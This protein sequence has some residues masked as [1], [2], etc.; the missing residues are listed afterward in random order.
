MVR[1]TATA[2]VRPRVDQ[3][4]RERDSS[5]D[6]GEKK[7][8]R[9]WFFT[10]TRRGKTRMW[11]GTRRLSRWRKGRNA[12]ESRRCW[13]YETGLPRLRTL[14]PSF[15][16]V[17]DKC[18]NCMRRWRG[19]WTRRVSTTQSSRCAKDARF[20][21]AGRSEL[22]SPAMF[23]VQVLCGVEKRGQVR[24]KERRDMEIPQTVFVF[25]YN[26]LLVTSVSQFLA[27][28]D[29]TVKDRR[30]S[31]MSGYVV[32]LLEVATIEFGDKRMI[33][34][35]DGMMT[36]PRHW[37]LPQK[38]SMGASKIWRKLGALFPKPHRESVDLVRVYPD[39]R[40]AIQRTNRMRW[41]LP[42][43]IFGDPIL[44]KVA[45][46]SLYLE[47]R[48]CT[49]DASGHPRQGWPKSVQQKSHHFHKVACMGMFLG[50]GAWGRGKDWSSTKHG[51][52]SSLPERKEVQAGRPITV[53]RM[54]SSLGRRLW[55]CAVAEES[56]GKKTRMEALTGDT[57][58]KASAGVGADGLADGFHPKVPLDLRTQAWAFL[59]NLGQGGYWPVQASTLFSLSFS[60]ECH[61]CKTDC[62]AA[63][64]LQVVG[65]VESASHPMMEDMK[66][67]AKM[68][69]MDQG[70]VTLVVDSA[71]AF[72]IVQLKVVW[73]WMMHF[74]DF[75]TISQG[76][77]RVLS[78]SSTSAAE[79][80]VANEPGTSK[81]GTWRGRKSYGWDSQNKAGAVT[82]WRRERREDSAHCVKQVL[83]KNIGDVRKWFNLDLV[84]CGT[85][86]YWDHESDEKVGEQG[87]RVCTEN[88]CH[89]ENEWIQEN[90]WETGIWWS[91][92]DGCGDLEVYGY[93]SLWA[94]RRPREKLRWQLGS[95]SGKKPSVSSF[96]QVN[97]RIGLC[98]M[99]GDFKCMRC[100]KRSI[101]ENKPSEMVQQA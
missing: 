55:G 95:A 3:L 88:W 5:K 89:Q 76:T 64:S 15:F 1:V 25:S 72:E 83:G 71:R 31:N 8:E 29:T 36:R 45:R 4:I 37:R 46:E 14:L 43:V 42:A 70:A 78:V 9:L 27:V 11:I 58:D 67:T 77:L 60:E 44:T 68:N 84:Q 49:H 54:C 80:F 7:Y 48:V 100:A 85:L 40:T 87:E 53:E 98:C 19:Q 56:A 65:L 28:L 93:H 20:F 57:P 6:D 62:F 92:E 22:S 34:R 24:R 82:D 17:Q 38:I 86:G 66:N 21:L 39:G 99:V 74:L 47:S 79:G 101:K 61:E 94:W 2:K 33:L 91:L 13:T 90:V 50:F 26:F 97:N 16:G 35:S 51:W 32:V 63:Y 59:E 96:F 23:N 81:S 75:A 18:K 12:E 73:A 10:S 41:R 69:N 30:A 52:T